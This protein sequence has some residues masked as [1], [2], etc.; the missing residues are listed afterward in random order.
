M[1]SNSL[2][3]AAFSHTDSIGDKMRYIGSQY[4]LKPDRNPARQENMFP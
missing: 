1:T 4:Y 3:S 2:F